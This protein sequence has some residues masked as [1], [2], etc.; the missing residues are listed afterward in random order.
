MTE[1]NIQTNPDTGIRF[2]SDP[3]PMEGQSVDLFV[4]LRGETVTNPTG[5]K[6]LN[7]FGNPY[8]EPGLEFYLKTPARIR[9]YDSE[10]FYELAVWGPVPY[11]NPKPGGPAG[12]W[13]ETLEVLR[14][15]NEELF[16][17]I[18]SRR[19]Q[20]NAA[21]YPEGELPMLQVLYDEALQRQA[22]LT[23][24]AAHREILRKRDAVVAA[25]MANFERANVLRADVIAGRQF[26][27][28]AG[29]VDAIQ[30]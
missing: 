20:A 23:A 12:R 15:P 7:L 14:R 17:Q 10:L 16:A 19:L 21:V 27:L 1:P 29:W 26:D 2:Y 22:A 24:S 9:E 13:E 28:N 5:V 6:W 3:G 25:G 8:S 30:S 18:E 11:A 4:P